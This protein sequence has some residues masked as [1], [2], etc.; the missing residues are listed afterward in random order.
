MKTLESIKN[1]EISGE[2]GN[3]NRKLINK[4]R[5]QESGVTLVAMAVTIVVLMMIAIPC[6]VNIK[7]VSETDKFTKLKNDITNLEESISQVYGENDNISKIGPK[8]TGDTGSSSFL[9]INQGEIGAQKTSKD[10]VKNPNDKEDYYVIDASKL[11]W[12]LKSKY[13]IELAD[14]N[15]GNNN[16]GITTL[17]ELNTK[18]VYIINGESRT[19]YYTEGVKYKSGASGK[20]YIYYRLPEDYTK[21]TMNTK[22]RANT[23]VLKKGMT[24]VKFEVTNGKGE[25]K[26]VTTTA[27]D[28][29]WYNYCEKRWANARTEDGSLWVWIPRFAYRI[30]KPDSSDKEQKGTTSIVFLDG[31]TDKYY[32]D[33]GKEGTAKRC[34]SINDIVDTTTGYTVHPAFTN[35]SSIGYRNGGW[36]SELYGIWVAKFEAAYAIK[37]DD[38]ILKANVTANKCNVSSEINYFY[39]KVGAPWDI[40]KTENPTV[41]SDYWVTARNHVDGI[42]GAT[43]TSIKYPTFQGS[44][45][46]MNYISPN[47]AYL[48]PKKLTATGNIYGLASDTD[49]H[50]IK[51]SEWGAV[52]YLSQ[53]WYG[54]EK[55]EIATNNKNFNNSGV[56]THVYAGTGYNDEG[57]VWNDATITRGN[58]ASTTGNIYGVYDMRGGT[59]ERV[60]AYIN[61]STGSWARS[62]FGASMTQDGDK[63][64]KYT[65]VYPS[66]ETSST[67]TND[68]KS[69]ANYEASSKIYGDAI[70]ETSTKGTD[71]SSWYSGV[72]QFPAQEAPFF[73]RS[74]SYRKADECGMFGFYGVN[75]YNIYHIGFRVTLI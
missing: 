13:G 62:T 70:R 42:Y 22:C 45:Y 48:L 53:S 74:G 46:S 8:Y 75:G 67:D 61:N 44:S 72:S 18:D 6:I 21:V 19:I 25:R 47:D 3:N 68:K 40:A 11:K 27:D 51:N 34:Q 58:S 71:I 63:S 50:L 15:Y 29:N 16:Y 26:T 7:T 39:S 35:E 59:W 4:D 10:V 33:N 14:L 54:L 17:T 30:N 69:Q 32:D 43:T 37:E 5:K 20:E 1:V 41:T 31:L 12:N 23:P 73:I 28:A 24:P 64:T 38:G 52:V 9:Y 65:T 56:A 57:K 36:D 49:S 55:T 2:N 66:N 60:A